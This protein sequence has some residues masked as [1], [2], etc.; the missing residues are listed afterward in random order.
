MSPYL[1]LKT[2]SVWTMYSNL[3]TEEDRWN[4]L[5]VPEAVRVFDYQDST[6]RVV[7]SDVPSLAEAARHDRRLAW[8]AFRE[9]A[10]D[11]PAGTVIYERDD[12]RIAAGPIGSDP[13][14][15]TPPRVIET[16]LLAFRDVPASGRNDCRSRRAYSPGQG[17]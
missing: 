13:V 12:R 7:A 1:G 8:V 15:R 16:A 6:V 11:H 10:S 14:L 9:M 4:H 2:Q 3:Q 17:S 5:L